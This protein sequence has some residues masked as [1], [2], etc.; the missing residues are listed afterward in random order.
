M[1]FKTPM[2]RSDLCYYSYAYA[3]VTGAI[4]VTGTNKANR[5]NKELAFK[6]STPFTSWI[7]KI[8]NMFIGNA[9][10]LDVVM[11]MY[12]LLENSENY[13]MTSGSL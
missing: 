12:N 8:N 11:P 2:L 9:E 13:S 10:D 4:S 1:M 6:N 3:A 7:T 5:R